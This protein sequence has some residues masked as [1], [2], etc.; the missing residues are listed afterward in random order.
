MKTPETANNLFR[1]LFVILITAIPFT[2]FSQET[3]TCAEKLKS[4]QSF[5]EKGQVEQ[6]PELLGN[7]LKS[8][9]KKEEELSAYKLLIQ[10]FLLDDDLAQA[11][12]TMYAFLKKNP[13]YKTSPTDHSSFVY[14]YNNFVVKPVIQIG[15]RAGTN[16]PFLTFVDENPTSGEPGKSDYSTNAGNLFFSVEAKFKMGKKIEIGIGAGYSQLKFT[17]T[18]NYMGFGIVNYSE[19]QQR[20]EIPA[21]VTYDFT[22]FG[23]FSPYGRLGLGAAYNLSTSADVSFNTTD[24]NNPNNRTG[25]TLDRKDSRVPLDLFVQFGAGMKYKIPR[26]Y[27]F[28]EVRSN[29]GIMNQNVSDGKT[30]DLLENYYLWSDPGFRINSLNLNIGYTFIL[31]K[32]SKKK[33]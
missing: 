31:F 12:S 13:E 25:E 20:L 8:G 5:F 14:L 29:F 27:L 21:S 1:L 28:A 16:I 24:K 22:S 10:T 2:A 4:A 6:V 7:C 19:I 18:V 33:E 3:G 15:I 9:F 32:P 26:G 23:K 30:V 17:N 11:D